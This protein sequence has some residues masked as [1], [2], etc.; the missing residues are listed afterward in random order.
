V[1]QRDGGKLAAEALFWTL[2]LGFVTG[3]YRTLEEVRQ[4]YL[5]T[6]GGTLSYAAFH[7]WFTDALCKFLRPVLESAL[8]DLDG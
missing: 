3:H 1:I 6:C 7:D 8:D 5:N 2:T 4:K